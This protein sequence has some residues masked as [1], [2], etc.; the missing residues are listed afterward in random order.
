MPEQINRFPLLRPFAWV[1]QICRYIKKGFSRKNPI[2]GLFQ[3]V[4]DLGDYESLMKNLGVREPMKTVFV[5]DERK[6][7]LKEN[8]NN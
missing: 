7:K 5:S 4:S 3:E 1:Y 2:K 8:K 6:R